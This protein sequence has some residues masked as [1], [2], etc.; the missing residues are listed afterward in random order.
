MSEMVPIEAKEPAVRWWRW[1]LGM[2]LIGVVP[3]VATI[4][5]VMLNRG[6]GFFVVG[7]GAMLLLP[8]L[9]WAIPFNIVGLLYADQERKDGQRGLGTFL[10]ILNLVIPV[11]AF[12]F[13]TFG[14]WLSP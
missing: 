1:S 11:A 9:V 2:F 3:F 7:I 4:V 13:A 5:Y 14:I 12:F 6:S 10:L 8:T